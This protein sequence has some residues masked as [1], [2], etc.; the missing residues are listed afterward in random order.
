[1]GEDPH[2]P[3][4][5]NNQLKGEHYTFRYN[6]PPPPEYLIL[7]AHVSCCD[8][9]FFFWLFTFIWKK[10]CTPQLFV[11]K[12]RHWY[13]CYC[14]C[15]LCVR[16]TELKIL[17]RLLIQYP[18]NMFSDHHTKR[19]TTDPRGKR[20]ENCFEKFLEISFTFWKKYS[21]RWVLPW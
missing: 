11:T 7:R 17:H 8:L 3:L 2:T 15:S 21:L 12:L 4:E 9:L 6:P 16:C 20:C 5:V 18:I 14:T 19:T 1:M 13:A 10:V